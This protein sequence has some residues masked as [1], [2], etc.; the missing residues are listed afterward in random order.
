MAMGVR[1]IEYEISNGDGGG[2]LI[3][4]ITPS[5]TPH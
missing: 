5:S 3:A 4:L 2:E 1:V